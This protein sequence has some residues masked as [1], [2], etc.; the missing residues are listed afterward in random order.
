MFAENTREEAADSHFKK[1]KC[2]LTKLIV[3]LQ[4]L[5]NPILLC[6]GIVRL[7]VSDLLSIQPR[8]KDILL[9]EGY[10]SQKR[11]SCTF[12][13]YWGRNVDFPSDHVN[14]SNSGCEN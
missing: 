5:S 9:P 4:K 10:S 11:Y 2:Y 6:P 14:Y 3:K 1:G 7:F 8:I 13:R 12:V